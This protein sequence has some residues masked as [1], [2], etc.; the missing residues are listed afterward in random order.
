MGQE[1]FML[2]GKAAVVRLFP[3]SLG[4]GGFSVQCQEREETIGAS[5]LDAIPNKFGFFP[6]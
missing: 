2:F 4:V 3:W 6:G 5:D 1:F